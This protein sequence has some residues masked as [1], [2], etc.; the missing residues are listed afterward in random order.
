MAFT[1]R[2]DNL[3][4][5]DTNGDTDVFVHDRQT[6]TTTR[7]SVDSSGVQGNGVSY[8][9]DISGN[10]ISGDGRFVTFVSAATN[11]VPGDTNGFWDAFVHCVAIGKRLFLS[12]PNR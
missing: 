2:A 7:V 12:S 9:T 1:S 8:L 4:P 11:L 10:S 5:G 3:V 6:G